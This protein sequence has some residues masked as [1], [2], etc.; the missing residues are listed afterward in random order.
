[1]TFSATP[2]KGAPWTYHPWNSKSM[3]KVGRSVETELRRGRS[4]SKNKSLKTLIDELLEKEIIRPFK[5]TVWTQVYLVRKPTG[6]FTIDYRALNKVITNE[7]R[8]ANTQYE[9][10]AAAHREPQATR[11]R[12]SGSDIG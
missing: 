9:R 1:M 12:G 6:G 5:A 4:P 2:S 11:F 8:M 7:R 3:K 10:Y